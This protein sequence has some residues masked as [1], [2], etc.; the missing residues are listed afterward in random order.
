LKCV[1]AESA[2]VVNPASDADE[3]TPATT[4]ILGAVVFAATA[5]AGLST[6]LLPALLE[7]LGVDTVAGAMLLDSVSPVLHA[8]LPLA[9]VYAACRR[10]G[11]VSLSARTVAAVS[12]PV[13]ILGRY[14]G[15]GVGYVLLGNGPPTPLVLVS[16]ADLA[17]RK[18]GVVLWAAVALSVVG[19]GLWGTVGALGGVGAFRHSPDSG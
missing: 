2:T 18:F 15:T 5:G 6:T 8:L 7:S 9:F 13:A 14:V 4:R 17:V 3:S 11:G 1:A 12:L 10:F 19:A 16:S